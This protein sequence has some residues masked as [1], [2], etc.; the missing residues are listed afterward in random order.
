M[1]EFLII[2]F[3]FSSIILIVVILQVN[4]YSAQDIHVSVCGQKS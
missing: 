2:R 3:S 1:E 4:V